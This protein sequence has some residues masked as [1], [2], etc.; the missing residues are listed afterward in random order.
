MRRSIKLSSLR[1]GSAF[2][3]S[4]RS[5]QQQ[6]KNNLKS[7]KN[8]KTHLSSGDAFIKLFPA[9]VADAAEAKL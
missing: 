4:P 3:R 6:L 9:L 7:L 8:V 1:R 5:L 2:E